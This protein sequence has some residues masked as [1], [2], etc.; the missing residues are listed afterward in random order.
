[1]R[2]VRPI[3][4]H[5]VGGFDRTDRDDVFVGSEVAH[6]ADRLDGQQDDEGLGRAVVEIRR[7]QLVDEDLV[8]VLQQRHAFRRDLADDADGQA[9]SGERMA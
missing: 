9:G 4:G 2:E 8:R 6:H 1:M 5:E 3:G 7:A